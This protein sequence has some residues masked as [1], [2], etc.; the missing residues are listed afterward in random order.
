[1]IPS[2]RMRW[3]RR[4]EEQDEDDEDEDEEEADDEDDDS[5]DG[6][7]AIALPS[8]GYGMYPNLNCIYVHA[9][10]IFRPYRSRYFW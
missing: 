8:D 1:M 5:G 6:K 10:S 9:N 7:Y 2:T 4:R 3:R